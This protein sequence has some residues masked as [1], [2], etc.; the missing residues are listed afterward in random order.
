[1]IRVDAIDILSGYIESPR[2]T[3]LI[4][5]PFALSPKENWRLPLRRAASYTH[6][7]ARAQVISNR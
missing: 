5:F 2:N 6:L 3:T 4:Q 7:A 1:L